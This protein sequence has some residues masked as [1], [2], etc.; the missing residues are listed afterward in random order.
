MWLIH[1]C[2]Y[3]VLK[4]RSCPALTGLKHLRQLSPLLVFLSDL[5]RVEHPWLNDFALKRCFMPRL[6]PLAPSVPR[7]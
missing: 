5:N 6:M 4:A 3:D 2:S 7:L 1:L